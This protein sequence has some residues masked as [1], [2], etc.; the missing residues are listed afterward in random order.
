MSRCRQVWSGA[1]HW[2]TV[3][4]VDR[5]TDFDQ[6]PALAAELLGA[7]SGRFHHVAGV[8][9]AAERASVAVPSDDVDLLVAA[10]WLHDIG[11][12]PP[13]TDTGFH[14]L[15]GARF[16]R[17]LG[18]PDRLC[19]LVAHH[20]ASPV[21]AAGRGLLDTLMG[22][23][24]P[25]VSATAD[26]LTYADLTTGPDGSPVSALERV[27]EILVRYPPNHVVHESIQRA[28]PE[29]LDIV[30]R[31]DACLV[32]RRLVIDADGQDPGSRGPGCG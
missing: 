28:R 22:E 5:W 12:A 7:D 31:V 24:P 27:T 23:F 6:A 15:D 3:S 21:E 20:T 14:P 13:L 32:G 4:E 29:L 25:E 30:R 8:A 2:P 1:A 18:A 11:Y 16:L 19:R 10:A 26:V 9:A 17:R